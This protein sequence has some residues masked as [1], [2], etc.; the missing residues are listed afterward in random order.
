VVSTTRTTRISLILFFTNINLSNA[1][2]D[3]VKL[4]G[5]EFHNI[6]FTDGSIRN[7]CLGNLTIEDAAYDGM[8]IEGIPVTE[9]LRV[10]REHN[11]QNNS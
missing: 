10:Y 8:C 11:G 1:K 7:A 9:L 3:D 6:A 5:V 4:S 2:F